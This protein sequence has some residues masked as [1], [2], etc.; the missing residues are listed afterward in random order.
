VANEEASVS[1]MK[2]E[3]E[4]LRDEIRNIR[5]LVTTLISLIVEDDPSSPAMVSKERIRKAILEASPNMLCRKCHSN[6][7]WIGPCDDCRPTEEKFHCEMCGSNDPDKC[8]CGVD[9][10]SG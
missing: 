4:K 9:D 5:V 1:N 7:Q 10:G 8:D 6:L 2:S 3:V